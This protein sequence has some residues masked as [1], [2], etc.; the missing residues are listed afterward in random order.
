MSCSFAEPGTE[1]LFTNTLNHAATVWQPNQDVQTVE[2][3]CEAKEA[4]GRRLLSFFSPHSLSLNVPLLGIE[5]AVL[6]P[7][8]GTGPFAGVS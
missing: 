3:L 4:V 8:P 7:Q 1:R 5:A 2:K 6:T